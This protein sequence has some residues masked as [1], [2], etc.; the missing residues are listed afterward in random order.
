MGVERHFPPAVTRHA[1]WLAALMPLLLPAAWS[2]RGLPGLDWAFAWLPL[3]ALYVVLPVADYLLG[4]DTRNPDAGADGPYP[5]TVIPVVAALVH[6]AVLAWALSVIG[7]FPGAFTW[8]ALLGW[9]VSLGD[10]SSV[11]GIN[12]AHELIHR[13]ARVLR[14]LGGLLLSC[15]WYPG[16]KLEHVRW[17]H[18]HVATRHDPSSAARGANIYRHVPR[19]MLLNTARAWRLGHERARR[20]GRPLPW[21]GHEV[22][23]GF[24]ISAALTLCAAA[25]WGALAGW[26]MLLQGGVAAAQLE[27]INFIEHYGLRRQRR[28]NGSYEPPGP[29]HSW[30][31]DYWLSNVILLQL[32][33]HADHHTRPSQPFTR[34]DTRADAPLLPLGYAALVNIA[35]VPP[36]WRRLVHPRLGDTGTAR[37]G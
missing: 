18:L 31:S 11:V 25:A 35:L 13:K 9:I 14:G 30:D 8:P 7:R 23:A 15:V 28:A 10:I 29:G 21:L 4:R 17:H 1:Y 12:V 3:V 37:V 20:R 33:R 2:L 32:P 36:L 24:A 19:A 22:A 34:L 16:F 6:L 27:V 26:V 5:R